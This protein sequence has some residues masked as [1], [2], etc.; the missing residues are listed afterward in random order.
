MEKPL[1]WNHIRAFLATAETGSLSAAARQLGLTQPTL[2][3]QVN[4]LE[5]SLGLTLFERTGRSLALTDAARDLL[6]ETRQMGGAATR[7]ARRAD[8]HL[9]ALDGTIRITASDMMSVYIL[10]D[11]LLHLRKAAPRLRVDIVA[12]N[13]IRDILNREADIA[14]RHVRPTQPDLIARSLGETTA[15]LYAAQEYVNLRGVPSTLDDLGSHDFISF[16]DDDLL[17]QQLGAYGIPLSHAQF[18]TGSASGITA[19]TLM[20][21]GFG[22]LPMGDNIA[23]LFP[24]A[25][26]L[27]QGQTD[28]TFPTWLV[29][30]R[31]LQTSRRIRLV[32][33]MLADILSERID[34]V[35][36]A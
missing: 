35:A 17:I 16:G 27:L 4:A 29:T 31:D 11:V 18:R 34:E 9:N 33:D 25:V 5:E 30:H 1:D 12:A 21:K 14:I 22:I 24:D 13:D 20:R 36:S 2:G 7:L 26:R 19:W 8:G 28:V 10:P 32:F 23:G 6:E 15:H 3:R